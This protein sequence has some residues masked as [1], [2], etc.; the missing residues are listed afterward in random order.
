MTTDQQ[1]EHLWEAVQECSLYGWTRERLMAAVD[2]HW[3][4][5]K[6]RELEDAEAA[7]KEV[8]P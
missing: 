2:E 1:D 6:R 5:A 7:G 4:E 8:A 3:I